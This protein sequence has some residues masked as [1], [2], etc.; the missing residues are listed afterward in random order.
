MR[1]LVALS[2]LPAVWFGLPIPGI[3]RGLADALLNTLSLDLVYIRLASGTAGNITEVVRTRHR[4]IELAVVL[5]LL[6]Q[7]LASDGTTRPDAIPDFLESGPLHLAVTRFGIGAEPGVLVTG[8]RNAQFPTER[9]RL[10]LGVGANQTAIVLQRRRAE[11]QTHEERERLLVTLASIGDAVLTT[12]TR[13]QITF[14]NP[15]AESLTGWSLEHAIGKPITEVFQIVGEATHTTVEN[16]VDKVLRDGAI[17]G[18]ANHTLLIARDGTRRPIDDSAAPIRGKDG[19]IVGCVL[20]F[21]DISEKQRVEAELRQAGEQARTILESITDAFFALSRDWRFTYVNQQAEKLFARTKADL[22]GKSIWDEYPGLVGSEFE[23]AYRAAA[24]GTAGSVTSYFPDH[25][26]WYEVHAYPAR[27]GFAVYFRDVTEQRHAN[28]RIREA[29]EQFR[30]MADNIPQLSWMATPEG[31]IFWFNRRW[32]EYTGTT[33]EQMK[34]DGWKS[35]VGP[36]EL[37]RVIRTFAN[38]ITSGKPWEDTF[39]LRRHDGALRWHL[40]RA[41]PIKN[42]DGVVLRW[43]GSNT[44]ITEQ[45]KMAADLAEADRRKSEFLAIL[46][47]E[48][49]NPLAP[50]RTGLQVLK[51]SGDD[52]QAAEQARTMMDRQLAQM[53]RLVDDLMDVSRITSGK[54][55]L[56]KKPVQLAAVVNS[57]IETSRPLIEQMGHELTVTLPSQPITLDADLTRLAQVFMNLLNNAA[58]YSERG[59]QI[60]LTAEPRGAEVVVSVKD[61]GIG[62]DA[63]HLPAIFEM[64][65]QVDRSLEKAQGGLGIGLSLVKRLIELHGGTVDARSDGPNMG[66]EFVVRLPMVVEASRAENVLPQEQRAPQPALRILVVD[67]NRD[68]A[69]LLAMM[70]ESMGNEIRVAYDG[71]AAIGA[72]LDFC[73]DVVLLDI[74]L[75]KLNGYEACRRIRALDAGKDVLLIAQTGW[76]QSEDRRRTREAGFDHHLVKPLDPQVLRKLLTGLRPRKLSLADD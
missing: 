30:A 14:L 62:I 3:A 61:N 15:V 51:L 48:L 59:G 55:E 56:R 74:G 60:Q 67:D 73:P 28:E 58:K 53:V 65:S 6:A 24:N 63:D 1:D 33:F 23:S 70:L 66:S 32:Y 47:H 7:A 26:R 37:P 20:V 38:S 34:G 10:L 18:L 43:F 17:I 72:T 76:G 35:F 54:I 69:D 64:F 39:A 9:D 36:D 75:P 44:D 52:G 5:P 31:S 41:M 29:E 21:R 49:R 11:D 50:I 68:G 25:A 13:G 8:C 2:T 40:S 46:A 4:N 71:E 45:R 42:Q 16:P 27:D 57:A 22:V 12:D 19:E